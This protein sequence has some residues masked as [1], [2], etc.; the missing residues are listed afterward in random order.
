M[1]VIT[2]RQAA[3]RTENSLRLTSQSY[4]RP[5]QPKVM[6]SINKTSHRV[7]PI[8]SFR[9]RVLPK[10]RVKALVAFSPSFLHS[11]HRNFIDVN[12][13]SPVFSVAAEAKRRVGCGEKNFIHVWAMGE[14]WERRTRMRI[15]KSEN[16]SL[17]SFNRIWK[18]AVLCATNETSSENIKYLGRRSKK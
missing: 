18:L 13:I 10:L 15:Y 4:E 9:L 6:S 2:T 17:L 5:T 7:G 14:R 1:S 3:K 8:V 12:F 16:F 11:T